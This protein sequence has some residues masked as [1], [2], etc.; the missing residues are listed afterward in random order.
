MVMMEDCLFCKIIEGKLPS[1]KVYEDAAVF[2]FL[3]VFPASEGHTLVAP[4][5]HFSRFTE[6]YG[7]S[8]KG[9]FGRRIKHRN[10]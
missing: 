6:D 3:D 1:E 5:K 8:R 9:I 10:Q 7:C 2:A 4:K